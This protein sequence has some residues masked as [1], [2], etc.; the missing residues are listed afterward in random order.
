MSILYFVN[1]FFNAVERSISF[2]NWSCIVMVYSR[3]RFCHCAI[4]VLSTFATSDVTFYRQLGGC[5]LKSRGGL[6]YR[7]TWYRL[8]FFVR[9][10]HLLF[11]LNFFYTFYFTLVVTFWLRHVLCC[12][13]LFTLPGLCPLQM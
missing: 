11:F 13:F 8:L 1:Y 3:D 7:C 6:P 5:F 10:P 9:V 2:R 4:D 12:V